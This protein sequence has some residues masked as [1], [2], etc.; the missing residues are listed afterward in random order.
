MNNQEVALLLESLRSPSATDAWVEFLESYAPFLYQIARACT[1][2]NGAATDC[3]VHICEELAHNRF[4]RLLKF[5]P[6]GRGSFTT[7]LRVVARNLC[8]DWHRSQSGRQRPFKSLQDLSPLELEI[9]NWRFARGASQNETL[10]YVAQAF[11]GVG[12]D[13]VSA[14]EERLQRSLTTHQR[15]ILSTRNRAEV[16][17]VVAEA[18]EDGQ[19]DVLDMADPQLD[20]ET[21]LILKE[22]EQHLQEILVTLP[23]EERL[24]VQLR[25]EHD[26]SLDEIAALCRLANGQ[27]VHRR[28][29]AV[30][31]KVRSVMDKKNTGKL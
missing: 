4:K 20:Q 7:W 18:G 31:K 1:A 25:F 23:A 5:N 17:T 9:Y 19:F 10:G 6:K 29:T 16:G 2:D 30:L 15:W 22:Q 27:L 8:F 24:L 21:L 26:L 3:Y 12:P 14:A 28:L 11:P 13:E